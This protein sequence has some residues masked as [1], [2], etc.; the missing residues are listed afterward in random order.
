MRG[1]RVRGVVA[2]SAAIDPPSMR[3]IAAGIPIRIGLVHSKLMVIDA[4][5]VITGSANW[6]A[7]SWANNENSLWIRDATIGT[8]YG[9]DFDR[10]YAAAHAP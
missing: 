9:T 5:T 7:A 4:R 8:A 6:T 1:V 3:M 2:G 10:V